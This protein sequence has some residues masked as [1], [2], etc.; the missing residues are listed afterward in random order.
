MSNTN[1]HIH[2]LWIGKKLAPTELLTIKSFLFH[3]HTFH[4]WAYDKLETKLPEGCILHNAADIIPSDEVFCYKYSN[5][6]G[7][8]K[9]SYAGF[10]DIFRYKLLH[11]QGGW[12]TDMDVT[13]LKPLDFEEEYVFRTHHSL[14]LVGNVMKCPK[15]SELMIKCYQQAKEQVNEENRDWHLPIQILADNVRELKLEQN[16]KEFSNPDS[17]NL[18]RKLLRKGFNPPKHWYII[19]WVNEEWRRNGMDK[20]SAL[21]SSF[22]YQI[23]VKFG[24]ELDALK[25]RRAFLTRWKLSIGAYI[26]NKLKWI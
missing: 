5:Q 23:G 2:A 20:T 6:F 18:I 24:I 14:P 21:K 26:T 7:H 4:L 3:K 1:Q 15:G 12:W 10:S 13:C 17:W 9:G 25:G 22:F 16:I 8:G 19:H 11:E